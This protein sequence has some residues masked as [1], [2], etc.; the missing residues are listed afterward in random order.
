MIFLQRHDNRL[1]FNASFS[2]RT[3]L[4]QHLINMRNDCR[5]RYRSAPSNA[6]PP[7]PLA[8]TTIIS[9]NDH[10]YCRAATP[11]STMTEEANHGQISQS[12]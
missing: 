12:W 9:Y 4:A 7:Y 11:P 3:Q 8:I 10:L 5:R 1:E 2:L 6:E